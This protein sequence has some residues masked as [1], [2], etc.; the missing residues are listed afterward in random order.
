MYTHF[1]IFGIIFDRNKSR[2]SFAPIFQDKLFSESLWLK[3][4]WFVIVL[5][6]RNTIFYPDYQT[7]ASALLCQTA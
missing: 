7:S 4:V 5:K 1:Y 2:Y 6:R 3:I